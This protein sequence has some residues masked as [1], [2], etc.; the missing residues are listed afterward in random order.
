MNAPGLA[1]L[2]PS[3]LFDN[4]LSQSEG[5][6]LFVVDGILRIQRVPRPGG[7]VSD[8]E[9][10]AF[11]RSK[12]HQYHMS[13]ARVHGRPCLTEDDWASPIFVECV[14][15]FSEANAPR[16]VTVS[17]PKALLEEVRRVAQVCSESRL[18]EARVMWPLRWESVDS[19]GLPYL[20]FVG[21]RLVV[22]RTTFM[23]EAWSPRLAGAVKSCL[24][25]LATFAIEL[26]AGE[27]YFGSDPLLLAERIEAPRKPPSGTGA[28][29][30]VRALS[31]GVR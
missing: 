19:P 12:R 1:Q 11:V 21:D 8:A 24:L 13:A 6:A 15:R 17:E 3:D 18:M 20:T 4:T 16:F 28:A 10:L 5:W 9:A 2:T 23:F 22:N 26:S 7:F 14:S 27:K 25:D 31:G 30:A 29:P